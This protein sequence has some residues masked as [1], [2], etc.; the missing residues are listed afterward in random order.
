MQK[1]NSFVRISK[2]AARRGAAVVSLSFHFSDTTVPSAG[3][4]SAAQ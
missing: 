1:S 2:T 4:M 3:F